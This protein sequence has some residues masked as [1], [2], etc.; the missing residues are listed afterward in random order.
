MDAALVDN[1]LE[2]MARL[3]REIAWP[4]EL[5]LTRTLHAVRQALEAAAPPATTDEES[6]DEAAATDEP[7][8][9]SS[10]K[11]RTLDLE[12]ISAELDQLDTY[13]EAGKLKP[14]SRLHRSL[15]DRTEGQLDSERQTRLRQLGARVAEL[16]DWQNFVAAPEA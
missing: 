9:D 14:A 11:P 16:R 8:T 6:A 13:L 1:D 7:A 3:E 4:A 12:A 15:R 10:D 2:Q 5:P